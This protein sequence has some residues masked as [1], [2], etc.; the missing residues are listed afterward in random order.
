MR[1]S[2]LLGALCVAGA[3]ASPLEKRAYVTEWSV[4]TVTTTITAFPPADPTPPPVERVD[5]STTSCSKTR[6]AKATAEPA[7]AP[8]NYPPAPPPPPPPPPKEPATNPE[9]APAPPKNPPAPPPPPPEE[10]ATNPEPVPAS[11]NV[12]PPPPAEEPA[13][14]AAPATTYY[15]SGGTGDEQGWTSYWTSSWSSSWAGST[16]TIPAPEPTTT[17]PGPAEPA[18]TGV[19]QKTILKSHNVHRSNH[20]SSELNYSK[21]LQESANTLASS[22]VYGHNTEIGGGNYGQNI[23]YGVE[24]D[25]VASLI[26][27]MMYNDEMGYFEDLYGQANPDMT[28]FMKWGHFTQIVWKSTTHVGCATVMCNK[29]TSD[30]G[31]YLGDNLPYTV[32]NYSPPGNFGGEYANNVLRPLGQSVVTA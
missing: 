14:T 23:G 6:K 11:P 13:T 20:S 15:E 9:P 10:P 1:S 3:M 17:N 31:S 25:N 16:I 24:K 4:V 12:P 2:M 19:F 8:P 21:E 26:T 32:C 22:C 18:P 5:D 7:P 27:D 30:D 29:L 28:N